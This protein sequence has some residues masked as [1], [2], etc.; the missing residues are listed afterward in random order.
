VRQ[1]GSEAGSGMDVFAWPLQAVVH[2]QLL[3]H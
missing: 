2:L 3:E 1:S